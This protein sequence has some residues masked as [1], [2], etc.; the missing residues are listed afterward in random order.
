MLQRATRV[1]HAT[2]P[3]GNTERRR[4]ESVSAE[5]IN[6]FSFHALK[7]RNGTARKKKGRP[8][9]DG[10]SLGRKR[11][12]RAAPRQAWLGNVALQN[13]GWRSRKGKCKNCRAAIT[14]RKSRSN[15]DSGDCAGWPALQ[16]LTAK[17]EAVRAS[18]RP[19]S[20]EETP[21]L[22]CGGEE[23]LPETARICMRLFAQS[24]NLR[25]LLCLCLW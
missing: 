5:A 10:P 13:I 11:P 18:E 12:R 14:G 4:A 6:C 8:G 25:Y 19:K 23:V 1:S 15:S 3:F 24:G 2:V 17:K 22:G 16:G 7:G 9:S 21:V 20:R